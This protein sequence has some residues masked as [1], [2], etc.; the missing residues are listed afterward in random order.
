MN[1]LT[2]DRAYVKEGRHRDNVILLEELEFCMPKDQLRTITE[3]HNNGMWIEDIAEEV[4]RNPYEV[5]LALI[6]Q[7]KRG[8]KM[9][10]LAVR[11]KL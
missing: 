7:V 9:R 5:L 4:K 3:L 6:H 8:Y 1:T 11:R 2:N 10:P